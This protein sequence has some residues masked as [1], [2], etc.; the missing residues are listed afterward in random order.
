MK[1]NFAATFILSTVLLLSA[2]SSQNTPSSS[3]STVPVIDQGADQAGIPGES[4]V[5]EIK[6]EAFN[7][8]FKPNMIEL[9]KGEKVKLVVTN[10]G[11][12]H[13]FVAK[14]LNI[15][16]SLV[17]DGATVIE[18]TPDTAGTFEFI[19]SIGNHAEQGMKGTIVVK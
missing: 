4:A 14:D 5:K 6:V 10:T 9:T 2:C 7:F 11:G 3:D 19:C 1:K 16:Q 12:F 15:S 18:V 8:G 17:A 13:D